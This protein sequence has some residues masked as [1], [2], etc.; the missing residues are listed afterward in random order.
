MDAGAARLAVSRVAAWTAQ[1][2]AY[3]RLGEVAEAADL[4]RRAA[5]ALEDFHF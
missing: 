5:E 1:G 2:D 3:R 4:Y